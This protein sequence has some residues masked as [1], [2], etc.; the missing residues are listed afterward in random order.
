M[1][2]ILINSVKLQA[3]VF[4]FHTYLRREFGIRRVQDLAFAIWQ[5]L[6]TTWKKK[7]VGSVE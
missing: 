7:L 2:V 3:G 6:N 4:A 5:L 1:E